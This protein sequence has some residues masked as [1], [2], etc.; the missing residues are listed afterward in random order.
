MS[1]G[2]VVVENRAQSLA[3]LCRSLPFY[4]EVLPG[5][6]YGAEGLIPPKQACKRLPAQHFIP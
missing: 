5:L 2:Y 4:G 1:G 3:S 6:V